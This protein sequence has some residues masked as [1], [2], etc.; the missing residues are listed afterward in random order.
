MVEAK[1]ALTNLSA[2][3]GPEQ[4]LEA[5][6]EA[7]APPQPVKVKPLAGVAVRVTKLLVT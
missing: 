1:E 5:P 4:V 2:S 3:I 6:K 7:Q